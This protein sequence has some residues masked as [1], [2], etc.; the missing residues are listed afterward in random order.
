MLIVVRLKIKAR[1]TLRS[2]S[3]AS[4]Y[5]VIC[6]AETSYSLRQVH[7]SNITFLVQPSALGLTATATLISY[8]ELLTLTP[9]AKSLLEAQLLPFPSPGHAGKTRQ[10]LLNDLPVS[11]ADFCEAWTVLTAFEHD[12]GSAYLPSAQMVLKTLKKILTSV[13]AEGMNHCGPY[14]VQAV[15][16]AI[17]DPE[18]P[19][20]LVE[21]VFA[22]ICDAEMGG[23]VLNRERCVKAVGGWVLEAWHAE[24]KGSEMLYPTFMAKWKSAV[25]VGCAPL[26]KSELLKD[27]HSLLTTNR[28]TFVP[29]V[30]QSRK[31]V[32][33][34]A[35]GVARKTSG[36]RSLGRGE[37]RNSVESPLPS[38]Q[39]STG[40]PSLL[41]V[42]S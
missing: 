12:N 40:L 4:D 37:S 23:P 6:T 33:L 29:D 42:S 2:P 14:S 27:C 13:S 18:I 41:V 30:L 17:D 5:A 19:A 21:N 28:I 36:M 16:L 24:A 8:I 26:C 31:S 35:R 38:I 10:Q 7:S 3:P 22:R 15:V 20:G 34:K 11:D 9:N 32:L 39:P 1:T 25:P